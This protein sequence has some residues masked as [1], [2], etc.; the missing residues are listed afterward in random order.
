MG[1][2]W[3]ARRH[4][5]LYAGEVA[6]K[7]PRDATAS[8]ADDER[9]AREGHLLARLAHPNIARLLDAGF[10]NEGERYLVLEYVAGE[11]IDHYCDRQRLPIAARIRLFLQVCAAVSH[12]HANLIVHRDL[13]PSN[14]LVL[15]DGTVKL[16]DFGVAKLLVS[17]A[18]DPLQLTLAAGAAL[19]P[20]YAA[21]EQLDGGAITTATDVYALGTVLYG[22]LCGRRPFGSERATAMQIARAIVETQARRASARATE[23]TEDTSPVDVAAVRGTTPERLRRSLAGDLDNIVAQTLQKNPGQRYPSVQALADD[24]A[25]YL[26]HEPVRARADSVAYRTRKFLR[27]NWIAVAAAGTLLMAIAGGVAGVLWQARVAQEE[28]TRAQAILGFLVGLFNEADPAKAQGRDLTVRDLLA[29]GERDVQTHLADQPRLRMT[30]DGVLV[31]LYGKLGEEQKALPLAVARRDLALKLYGA[32]S[33]EYGDA[34]YDLAEVQANLGNAQLSTQINGQAEAIFRRQP[35][36]R[37][38]ELVL[39]PRRYALTAAQERRT[40]EAIAMMTSALTQIEARF[41]PQEWET[42]DTKAR[43]AGMYADRGDHARAAAIFAELEGPLASAPPEHALD[44]VSYRADQAYNLWLAGQYERSAQTARRTIAEFDRLTGPDNSLSIG[45]GRTLGMALLDGGQFAYAAKAFEEAGARA[46]RFFGPHDKE[47]ALTDSFAL[48][49]LVMVGRV[50]D[51]ES[52]ARRAMRDIEG[53]EGLTAGEARGIRRRGALALI[54][55]GRAEEARAVLESIAKQED[56]PK[57]YNWV[58]AV[59]LRYLAGAHAALGNYE[60][61]AQWSRKSL[62]VYGDHDDMVPAVGRAKSQLTLAR[63]LAA[64]GEVA[65]A[66]RLVATAESALR[67][68]LSAGH[69]N[70][71]LVALVRSEILRARGERVAADGMQRTARQALENVAGPDAPQRF[72]VVF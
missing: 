20:E 50:Q 57:P 19:T 37:E 6:I 31:D 55:A 66:E 49:A 63:A 69:A 27:R 28:A 68:I 56:S 3:L 1:Q 24:L 72:P 34:L 7:M 61:A 11:R 38:R 30:L 43:L 47:T 35:A 54:Y 33:L 21:P 45:A 14:I 36:A 4:D 41:G 12:A 51:A 44:V 48:P 58:H 29:R 64:Q 62:A 26:K 70:F 67:R 10:T 13:K 39:I 18:P 71:A 40:D 5:G 42:L 60:A 2:V 22:L 15:S 23:V 16:L 9:F 65:E 46:A 17:D 52:T 25:R 59:T 32:Q 53:K 8:P